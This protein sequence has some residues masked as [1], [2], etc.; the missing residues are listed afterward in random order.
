M[1]SQLRR[2]A[3]VVVKALATPQMETEMLLPKWLA[4]A[5][6]KKGFFRNT[7]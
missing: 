6:E 1:V 2:Q 5:L 3:A 7:V 4:A